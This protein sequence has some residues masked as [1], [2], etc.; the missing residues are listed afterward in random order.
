MKRHPL[1]LWARVMVTCAAACVGQLSLQAQSV[2]PGD[3]GGN[4][5]WLPAD[6]TGFGTS[7]TT[8]SN[9]WFTLEGGR[10]SELYYPDL[11]TPSARNID[12][13]VTDGQSFATRAQDVPTSTRLVNRPQ[14]GAR[15][16]AGG[17][18]T[19]MIPTA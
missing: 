15:R 18:K 14:G 5:T 2:A 13:V 19:A 9:V 4:A 6:K 10:L 11:S 3:P 7:H 17:V 1:V 12:F 16:I 8:A